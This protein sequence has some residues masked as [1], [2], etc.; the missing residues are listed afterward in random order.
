M[1]LHDRKILS[2]TIHI[3]V[4]PMSITKIK[5]FYV[6]VIFA[7]GTFQIEST[8]NGAGDGS[9]YQVVL[10]FPHSGAN[11]NTTAPRVY[12]TAVAGLSNPFYGG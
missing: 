9:I 12:P 4:N 5:L 2:S 1:L 10:R 6:L 7:H 11:T 8:L 3:N